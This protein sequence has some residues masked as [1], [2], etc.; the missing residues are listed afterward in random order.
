MQSLGSYRF[1]GTYPLIPLLD[2]T[3]KRDDRPVSK[4]I[5]SETVLEEAAENG[6]GETTVVLARRINVLKENTFFND[7]LR[8][9]INEI[10]VGLKTKVFEKINAKKDSKNYIVE[11]KALQSLATLLK[12]LCGTA[13]SSPGKEDRLLA[14]KQYKKE[15]IGGYWYSLSPALRTTI[16]TFIGALVG[17]VVGLIIGGPAALISA[18]ITAGLF[19]GAATHFASKRSEEQKL[20]LELVEKIETKL[21]YSL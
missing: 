6:Y 9:L 20:S 11:F 18:P 7:E 14:I 1:G 10:S 12:G 19:S 4:G 16:M 21:Q 5:H 8:K 2:E 3:K 13:D 17:F 15:V